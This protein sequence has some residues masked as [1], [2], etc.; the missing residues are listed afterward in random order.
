MPIND[1]I[2]PNKS[3]ACVVNP[4]KPR[5]LYRRPKL[6]EL[7]DLRTLTLGGSPGIGDSSSGDPEYPPGVHGNLPARFPPPPDGYIPFR[8]L[9]KP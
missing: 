4:S 9:P 5:K 1:G 2:Y 3:Q 7:G 8:D 6:E